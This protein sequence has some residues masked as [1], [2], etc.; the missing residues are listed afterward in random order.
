[1]GGK[2]TALKVWSSPLG[3]AFSNAVIGYAHE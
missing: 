3:D 2:M 1:M